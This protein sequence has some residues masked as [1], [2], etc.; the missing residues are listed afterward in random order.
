M[1]IL[2]PLTLNQEPVS[3]S[4]KSKEIDFC[5]CLFCDHREINE[6]E[7]KLILQHLYFQ[8][9]LIIADVHEIADLKKYLDYWKNEFKGKI[10]SLNYIQ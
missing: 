8:H 5:H 2:Q 3:N 10:N 1:S 7:N 4:D 9:R 6:N